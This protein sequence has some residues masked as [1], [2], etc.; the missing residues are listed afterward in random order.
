MLSPLTFRR[1]DGLF[2]AEEGI[3]GESIHW[4]VK[5]IGSRAVLTDFM[6]RHDADLPIGRWRVVLRRRAEIQPD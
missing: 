1:L 3:S 5:G 6:D 2:L 4:V